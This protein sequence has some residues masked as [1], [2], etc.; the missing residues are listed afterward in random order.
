MNWSIDERNTHTWKLIIFNVNTHIP[1][2][3]IYICKIVESIK[4]TLTQQLIE[5]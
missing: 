3:Y 2:M 4:I 5:S 1:Y